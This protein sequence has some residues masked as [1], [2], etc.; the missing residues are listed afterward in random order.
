MLSSSSL[1]FSPQAVNTLYPRQTACTDT[2]RWMARQTHTCVHTELSS[3]GDTSY[4]AFICN[5]VSCMCCDILE[6][7][8]YC[9]LRAGV[10]DL[11]AL[12]ATIPHT[13]WPHSLPDKQWTTPS[14]PR[15]MTVRVLHVSGP[16][17]RLG[18]QRLTFEPPIPTLVSS[19]IQLLPHVQPPTYGPTLPRHA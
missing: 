6:L 10:A 12:W 13:G 19:S 15:H 16:Y 7:L 14:A 2:D 17:T 11:S 5:G 8:P 18:E 3:R 1:C 9:L 4:L